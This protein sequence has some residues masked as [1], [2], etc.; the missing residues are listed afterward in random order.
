VLGLWLGVAWAGGGPQ[1]VMVLY[2]AD[3]PDSVGVAEHYE[4]ARG[5]PA[6]HLCGLVGIGEDEVYLSLEDYKAWVLSPLGDCLSALPQPEDIDYLVVARG[7]PYQVEAGGY[8]VSL[9]AA[10]QVYQMPSPTGSGLLID[11]GHPEGYAYIYNPYYKSGRTGDFTLENYY[12]GWYTSASGITRSRN[13]PEAFERDHEPTGYGDDLFIVTRLDGFDY[14]DARD[15]VDR[16]V[17]SD[18]TFPGADFLCMHG[19]DSARGARDPECEFAIQKLQ[20]LGLA[21]TWLAE[22]DGSLTG[23]EVVAYFTGAAS[24]QGAIDGQSYVPGAITC[25]LTSYGAVPN[26]FFCDESG[27]SC[28]ASESQTSIARYIRAGATGAHGTVNEPY[29]NVFPNAGALIHY[30]LGYSLGESYF[31]NQ[32]FLYWQNLTI[33]DP[34]A[35]PFAE[36]PVVTLS[37]TTLPLNEPLVITATHPDS[38]EVVRLYLDDVLIAEAEGEVLEWIAEGYSAGDT[39]SLRAVAESGDVTLTV[40][41]W[42][43]EETTVRARTQGW[44]LDTVTLAEPSSADTGTGTAPDDKEPGGCSCNASAGALSGAWLLL[45]AAL[46]ARRRHR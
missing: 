19:A 26:N 23:Y 35:T 29:N 44:T 15:V 5:L 17:A 25:N 9:S 13:Q 45:V 28:P 22:F 4:A 14:Q 32:L 18:G 21:A 2:N 8:T 10:L 40:P 1:N 3:V 27:D 20:E 7:L 43:Q 11:D 16:G 38:I 31:F 36:R 41:G 39:L 46:G 37:T 6:G 30:G 42:S 33:G 24:V 12:A 34:L